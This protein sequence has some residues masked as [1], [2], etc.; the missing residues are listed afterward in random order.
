MKIYHKKQYILN[1]LGKHLGTAESGV[2]GSYL[3]KWMSPS[4]RNR[5]KI[6]SVGKVAYQDTLFD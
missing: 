2:A 4:G 6:L 3:V 5:Y 1:D